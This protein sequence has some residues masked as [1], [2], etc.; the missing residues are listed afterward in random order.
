V[1]Q[2]TK[3]VT[4]L[5]TPHKGP[6]YLSSAGTCHGQLRSKFEMSNFIS[7]IYSGD[8]KALPNLKNDHV[9]MTMIT[10]GQFISLFSLVGKYLPWSV[11]TYET[12]TVDYW[13]T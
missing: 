8:S 7:F 4:S 3:W 12:C 9:T 2:I 11:D 6:I 10:R 5:T 1:I 13:H